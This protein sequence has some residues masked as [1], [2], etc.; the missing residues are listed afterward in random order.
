MEQCPWRRWLLSAVSIMMLASLSC[1]QSHAG[2]KHDAMVQR[3]AVYAQQPAS[4]DRRAQGWEPIRIHF[5]YGFMDASLDAAT[6][7]YIRQ[8]IADAGEWLRKALMVKRLS[9]LQAGAACTAEVPTVPQTYRDGIDADLLVFVLA[10]PG[11]AC[12]DDT[13][14]YATHCQQDPAN[15][16][17]IVGMLKM[18]PQWLNPATRTSRGARDE[19]LHTA[20]HELMHVVAWSQSLFAFFRDAQGNP[21]TPRYVGPCAPKLG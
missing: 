3:R 14:A 4:T 2:C 5:D 12:S 9:K 15:D 19:D 6:D 10:S 11:G 21:R 17:P 8:L 20:L 13:L 7:T 16:R 18:C 1:A